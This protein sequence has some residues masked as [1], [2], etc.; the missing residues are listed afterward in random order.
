MIVF[1]EGLMVVSL[2]AA[3]PLWPAQMPPR[4]EARLS[5]SEGKI[6][7]LLKG[8]EPGEKHSR[9][10]GHPWHAPGTRL[11]A[12]TRSNSLESGTAVGVK[13]VPDSLEHLRD[14]A[15]DSITQN[16]VDFFHSSRPLAW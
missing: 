1:T 10:G 8:T 16:L 11:V 3:G 14:A 7:V 15:S 5:A 6:E 13:A 2:I 12:S 9:H 4:I